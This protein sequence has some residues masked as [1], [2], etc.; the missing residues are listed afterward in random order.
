MIYDRWGE[1][2]FTTNQ[3]GEGWDGKY[4]GD[5]VPLGVYIY[6]VRFNT[7]EGKKFEK[8]STV[9]VIK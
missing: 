7:S 6:Y 9:T 5:Y 4:K 2:L 3:P 8:R 1:L